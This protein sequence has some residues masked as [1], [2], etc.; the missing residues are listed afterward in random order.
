M[1]ATSLVIRRDT[2]GQLIGYADDAAEC[3][4]PECRA[5]IALGFHIH[6]IPYG[7]ATTMPSYHFDTFDN[8]IAALHAAADAD[9]DGIA[10]R[11]D[12]SARIA[13]S[14]GN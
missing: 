5:A 10:K 11:N 12:I 14:K 1:S 4:N 7:W 3:H 8:A 13:A 2:D 9:P 6:A